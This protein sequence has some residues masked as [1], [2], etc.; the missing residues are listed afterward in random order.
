MPKKTDETLKRDVEN[1]LEF[2]PSIDATKIAVAATDGVVTLAGAVGSYTEKWSAESIAKRVYGVKGIANELEVGINLAE[3]RSDAEIARSA[4]DALSWNYS[5]P[6]DQV[7]VIVDKAWLTLD[8]QVTWDY[9]RRA[10]EEAVRN[11]RGVRGIT[12]DIVVRPA[13]TAGDV[14]RT[15]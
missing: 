3:Y 11:L 1:E 14:K 15:I 8:G 6:K 2:D 10:A 9:Q 12:N 4:V 5:V 7:K 13:S